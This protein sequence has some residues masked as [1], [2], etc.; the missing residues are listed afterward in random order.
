M[1]DAGDVLQSVGGLLVGGNSFVTI[2]SA[3]AATTL[4]GN[5][6][7]DLQFRGTLYILAAIVLGIVFVGG[8][9][10]PSSTTYDSE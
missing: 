10:A 3:L 2:T 4:D 6:F 9:L 7:I 1:S 5:A 8:I